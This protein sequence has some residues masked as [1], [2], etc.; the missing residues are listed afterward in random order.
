MGSRFGA[1]GDEAAELDPA[2]DI[3]NLVRVLI[4]T[5]TALKTSATWGGSEQLELVNPGFPVCWPP[6]HRALVAGVKR[7]GT[8]PL[9][10]ACD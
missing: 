8:A 1:G 10:L 5:D 7:V 9:S 3:P 2:V 6:L 4:A